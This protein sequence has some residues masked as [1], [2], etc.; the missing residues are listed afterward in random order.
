MFFLMAVCLTTVIAISS[1]SDFRDFPIPTILTGGFIVLYILFTIN[2]L[3][4]RTEH[5]DNNTVYAWPIFMGFYFTLFFIML[6]IWNFIT[7]G[8]CE[9]LDAQ[10]YGC[11][12]YR[13]DLLLT[14]PLQLMLQIGLIA[15]ITARMRQ[16]QRQ[17]SKNFT[18]TNTALFFFN[19]FII[20]P[21]VVLLFMRSEADV[22]NMS[23]ILFS[24]GLL[25]LMSALYYTFDFKPA[26]QGS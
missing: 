6:V 24:S 11:L 5:S 2:E 14:I 18:R 3:I 1:L 16:W 19:L 12:T 26:K 10:Q 17:T 21:I 20:S 22:I 9:I 4:Y 8:V 25:C 13:I 7:T 23:F 15:F